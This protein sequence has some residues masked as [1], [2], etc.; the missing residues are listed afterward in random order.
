MKLLTLISFILFSSFTSLFAF[1]GTDS[2]GYFLKGQD[3]VVIY[4]VGAGETL[5]AIARK[6]SISMAGIASLNPNLQPDQLREGQI[7]KLP[8][9]KLR[10]QYRAEGSA[11]VVSEPQ[12]TPATKPAKITQHTIMQGETLYAIARHYEVA[13]DEIIKANPGLQPDKIKAG[14]MIA[15]PGKKPATSSTSTPSVDKPAEPSM[16]PKRDQGPST[17]DLL[18]SSDIQKPSPTPDKAAST[19][20]P[21][22]GV[23][24]HIVQKGETMFSISRQYDVTVTDLKEWNN[25][26]NFQIDIGDE[27][28]VGRQPTTAAVSIQKE[29]QRE[30]QIAAQTTTTEEPNT[31]PVSKSRFAYDGMDNILSLQYKED[32]SSSYFVEERNN[33]IATWIS[34][35]DGYPYDNGYFALHRTLPIGTVVKVRNL[36]NDKIVFAKVIGRLPNTNANEKIMLKLPEAAKEDLKVLDAQLVM[37]VSY[38]RKMN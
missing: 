8:G 32:L 34:D 7:I 25:K 37:E 26:E 9:A 18:K 33:G 31:P 36:M 1:G 22:E 35:V 38:L 11:S 19:N 3:T 20:K 13:V 27:L 14:Q 29:S 15:I 28:I 12:V 10:K 5:S 30:Q 2:I 23:V 17:A 24:T 6:Y 16:N 4:E 21:S